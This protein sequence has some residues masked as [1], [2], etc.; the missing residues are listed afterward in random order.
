MGLESKNPLDY[1]PEEYRA[2]LQADPLTSG[3]IE[4]MRSYSLEEV[5]RMFGITTLEETELEPDEYIVGG[6]DDPEFADEFS[7]MSQAEMEAEL[8]VGSAESEFDEFSTMTQE[9][10]ETELGLPK[11]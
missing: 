2:S 5:V 9:G 10:M 7:T 1:T 3:D 8:Q 4:E 11:N 6:P